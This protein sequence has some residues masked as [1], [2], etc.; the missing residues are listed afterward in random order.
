MVRFKQYVRQIISSDFTYGFGIGLVYFGYI[1]SWMWSLYPLEMAGIANPWLAFTLI[2]IAFL[3]SVIVLALPWGFFSWLLNNGLHYKHWTTPFAIAGIFTLLEYCRSWLFGILWLGDGSILGPLW[4]FGNIAYWFS[5]IPWI[6]RTAAVWG[7]YGITFLVTLFIALLFSTF[8]QRSLSTK[9]SI[10]WTVFLLITV[11][12][13]TPARGQY[14]N[15]ID[16]AVVQTNN[17][18]RPTYTQNE[19]IDDFQKKL[20]L[21]SSAAK[22]LPGGG[23]ILLPEGAGLSTGFSSLLTPNQLRE[24]LMKLSPQ[25]ITIINNGKVM[26][27]N[28]IISRTQAITPEENNLEYH[29]K[30]TLSPWGEFRPYIAKFVLRLFGLKASIENE[31]MPGY[32]QGPLAVPQGLFSIAIC[33]EIFAPQRQAAEAILGMGSLGFFDGNTLVESQV[34]SAA[35]MR[36][37]ENQKYLVWAS[38]AGRSYFINDRGNTIKITS[39]PG[40]EILTGTIV[41]N[42]IRTWYNLLGDW[43]ILIVS[44]AVS[45]LALKRRNDK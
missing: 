20:T 12:G 17:P 23:I 32:A 18:T 5:D 38:N 27:D 7:M 4:T 30:R 21:I 44:L 40:Y 10:Q 22:Q 14:L 24:Y 31:L 9:L 37:A 42:N 34:L 16:V 33:S 2:L 1:F 3:L 35:R 43:P 41:S 28:N 25:G 39:Q 36:A 19:I 11:L 6:T 45:F 13:F 29:D 8:R 15:A 26:V